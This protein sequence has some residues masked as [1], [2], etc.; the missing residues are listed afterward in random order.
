MAGRP[1]G[2]PNKDKPFRDALRMEAA[3]AEQGQETPAFPGSL[4][5]IARQLLIRAGEETNATKE[6]GDRMDG[7]VPQGV[8]QDD[9]LGPQQY[10]IVTGVPRDGD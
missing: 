6:V 7:K 2:S 3:L 9:E 5:W 8:G 1:P 4:R 10:T